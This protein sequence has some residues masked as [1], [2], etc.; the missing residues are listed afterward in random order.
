MMESHSFLTWSVMGLLKSLHQKKL[1]PKNDP[2]ITQLQKSFSKAC[3][4]LASSMTSSTA[5]MTMKRRQL[6]LSHVVPSVSE[7]QKRNLLSDPFFQTGS[8]FDAS[9]VESARSAARDL[10][11]FKPHLRPRLHH[12][13][14]DDKDLLALQAVEAPLDSFLGLRL[15]SVPLPLSDSSLVERVMHASIRSLPEP[16]RSEGVFGSRSLVLHRRSAAA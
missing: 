11:L 16:P 15:H 4:S 13:N 12:L 10:S 8:L 6:L 2:V 14:P 5:F 1:L 3:S 9:S 7:A